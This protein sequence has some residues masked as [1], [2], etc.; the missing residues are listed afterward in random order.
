MSSEF[1]F[2]LG[3]KLPTTYNAAITIFCIAQGPKTKKM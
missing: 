3:D 1:T 2:V